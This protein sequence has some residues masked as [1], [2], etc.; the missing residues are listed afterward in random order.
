MTDTDRPE[1]LLFA[2]GNP[3]RGDDALGPMLASQ[4]ETAERHRGLLEVLTDFQ[5]QV[6]HALDLAGRELVIFADAS[7]S[8]QPP[9]E[10][11]PITAE[12]DATYTT[13]SM[14]PAAVLDVYRRVQQAPLP[15]CYLLSI[16]GYDFELGQPLSHHAQSN[17]QAAVAFLDQYLIDY[18]H[19]PG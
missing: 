15:D 4:L 5:F 7:L 19:S 12:A 11:M 2:C 16:R 10:F 6:E 9:Y 18:R 8:A 13:H 17:L 3:S 1:I 14:S